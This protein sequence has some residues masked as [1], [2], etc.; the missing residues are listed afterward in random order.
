MKL[1]LWVHLAPWVGAKAVTLNHSAN[2]SAQAVVLEIYRS[3]P[4]YIEHVAEPLYST[5]D[6]T[7]MYSA[8]RVACALW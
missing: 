5:V 2:K 1:C 3:R 6:C 8:A 7:G 4:T